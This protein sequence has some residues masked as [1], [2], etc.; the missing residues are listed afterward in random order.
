MKNILKMSV[1][2]I[3]ATII[4]LGSFAVI[5]FAQESSTGAISPQNTNI[6]EEIQKLQEERKTAVEMEKQKIEN[7]REIKKSQAELE[8]SKIKDLRD[9]RKLA[10]ST[11]NKKAIQKQIENEREAVKQRMELVRETAKNNF[12]IEKQKIE[13]IRESTKTKIETLRANL[14]KRAKNK[15][16]DITERLRGGTTTANI[17]TNRV[18]N[19]VQTLNKKTEILNTVAIRIDGRIAKME[20]QGIDMTEAKTH[21]AEGRADLSKAKDLILGITATAEEALKTNIPK[22]AFE[23]ARTAI[24]NAEE[25]VKSAHKHFNLA[26]VTIKNKIEKSGENNTSTSTEDTSTNQ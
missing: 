4:A 5:A 13:N 9:T 20:A 8:R 16:E 11:T 12:E 3:T 26:V 19:I 17:I 22:T 24:K 23:I 25:A 10:T 1:M 14:I 18:E 15:K 6:K 21:L 7:I 2:G